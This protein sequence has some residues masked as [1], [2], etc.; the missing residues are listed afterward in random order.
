MIVKMRVIAAKK[1]IKNIEYPSVKFGRSFNN[2]HK[3]E[4]LMTKK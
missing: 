2:K 4:I 3:M 1:D